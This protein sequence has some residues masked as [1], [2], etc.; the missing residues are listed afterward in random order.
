[1]Q[2]AAAGGFELA[3]DCPRWFTL[4]TEGRCRFVGYRPIREPAPA[5]RGLFLD[6]PPVRDGFTPAQID[7]GRY[8][9]FD[10][11][12]SR[13]RDLSCAH[14]H[15]PDHGWADGLGRSIGA[16]GRG[17]GPA[18]QGGV[19]LKRGAPSLWNAGFLR[20]LFLDGRAASLEQQA[21]GPLF[22]ADEMANTPEQLERTLGAVPAYQALFATAFGTDRRGGV[23]VERVLL[24][25]TAFQSTLISL[26][27]RYDRYMH[28]D[29][30][31]LDAHELR[32][33]DLFHSFATRCA[34][35]HKP[36]LFTDQEFA[37]IGAPEGPG[38]P[39]DPGVAALTGDGMLR[40]AFRTPSVR[41][42]TRTA[43]FMHSGGHATL[44]E[45]VR[46]YFE[47]PGTQ[48]PPEEHILLHWLMLSGGPRLSESDLD[49]L[50]AFIETLTDETAAPAVP[51]AV[52]S[53]LPVVPRS[54]PIA[55]A[56]P[57]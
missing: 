48:V 7:L 42:A 14:C 36:P 40:G 54:E 25:L 15:H 11:A 34:H 27:S 41:N 8:L 10:P 31:A 45:A 30:A 17:A 46:F 49:A 16:G 18:R 57:R 35:C 53:G 1:M 32:G 13:D 37:V 43:P 4:D 9:F 26:D 5:H 23:T 39:F 44:T 6:L 3:R 55:G 52:P 56:V 51:R 29:D 19:V 24:A 47:E 2:A 28:G 22:A 21:A 38:T 20:R 50:T 12:L 33:L